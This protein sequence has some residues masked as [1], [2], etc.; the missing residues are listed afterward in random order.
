MDVSR[1]EASYRK[2]GEVYSQDRSDR[3]GSWVLY[4][5]IQKYREKK[6]K[7]GGRTQVL[8]SKEAEIQGAICRSKERSFLQRK[9]TAQK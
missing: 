2:Q 7:Q 3:V 4:R 8:N 1:D 6:K 9:W 5:V